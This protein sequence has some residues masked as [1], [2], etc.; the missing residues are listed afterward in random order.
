M[1]FTNPK[2]NMS[3]KTVIIN[4]M[5][6]AIFA[7]SAPLFAGTECFEKS[8]NYEEGKKVGGMVDKD[9]IVDKGYKDTEDPVMELLACNMQLAYEGPHSLFKN[10][11]CKQAIK[12]SC[13]FSWKNGSLIA[14]GKGGAT[15]AMCAP[16]KP[17]AGF[18]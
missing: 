5:M 9:A 1:K 8:E 18:L 6:I 14:S 4:V 11:G 15:E 7:V 16:W 10:C 3:M 17:I 12:K 13:S 2:K